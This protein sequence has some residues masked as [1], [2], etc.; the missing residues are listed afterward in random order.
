MENFIERA[1]ALDVEVYQPCLEHDV[2]FLRWW[3]EMIASG[4]FEKVFASNR[5][6]PTSFM[7]TFAPPTLCVFSRDD[8]GMWIVVWW[9][10]FAG[11][12]SGAFMHYWCREDMRGARKQLHVSQLVYDFA[13][14]TWPVV[15]G[16]TKHEH[17][18]R[19]HRKI[20]YNILGKIPKLLEGEDMWVL[21]LTP[22]DW[23]NG[24]LANVGR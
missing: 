5:R 17:L 10:L 14:D 24:R 9:H 15:I 7:E 12:D 6:T 1:K 8:K 19:I 22:E 3:E 13:M 4:D 18:L 21:Y 11:M 23:N 16:L 2:A 20:G